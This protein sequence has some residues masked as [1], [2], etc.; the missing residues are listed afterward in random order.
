MHE[1]H[2]KF[3]HSKELGYTCEAQEVAA[4]ISSIVHSLEGGASSE[5]LWTTHTLCMQ[6]YNF[7]HRF[8][9]DGSFYKLYFNPINFDLKFHLKNGFR[10]IKA[11]L[12]G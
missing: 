12:H 2:C 10:V 7:S 11:L 4:P 1:R 8:A 5:L 6:L 3:S 9:E